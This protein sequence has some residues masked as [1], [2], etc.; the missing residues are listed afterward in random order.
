MKKFKIIFLLFNF[1]IVFLSQHQA[2]AQLKISSSVIGNG[3]ITSVKQF[4]NSVPK[5]FLLEQNYPIP[6]IRPFTKD[7]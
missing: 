7:S 6:L 2:E 4:S 5:E 1:A 3:L